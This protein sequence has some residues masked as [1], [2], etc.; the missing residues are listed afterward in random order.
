MSLERESKSETERSERER[1]REQHF[2]LFERDGRQDGREG[3][4][5]DR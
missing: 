4:G 1:E 2:S 3:E 5:E